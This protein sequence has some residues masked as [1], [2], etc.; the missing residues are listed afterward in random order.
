MQRGGERDGGEWEWEVKT[1][2]RTRVR[3]EAETAGLLC[4]YPDGSAKDGLS[5]WDGCP[6]A[7]AWRQPGSAVPIVAPLARSNSTAAAC[8]PPAA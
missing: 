3:E 2:A 7:R 1:R 6:S 5:G 4:Y 8:P